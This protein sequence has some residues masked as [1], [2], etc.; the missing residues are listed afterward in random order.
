MRAHM[1]TVAGN[2]A[3]VLDAA[4]RYP[5]IN[6]YGLN[7]GL[8]KTS[9]RSNFLGEGSLR[10]RLAEGLIGLLTISADKYAR[11][12]APLLF[13]PDIE[14]ASGIHFNQKAVAILPSTVMNEANVA[15]WIHAFETLLERA[16]AAQSAA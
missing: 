14:P 15:R 13:S 5:H 10:H 4:Q 16:L 12:M 7:P 1:N 3:L 8:I 9:I 11:R 2:E 6:V